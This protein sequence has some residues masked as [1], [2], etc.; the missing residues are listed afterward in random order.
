MG[1]LRRTDK[2]EAEIRAQLCIDIFS[3]NTK[4]IEYSSTGSILKEIA[5]EFLEAMEGA[6]ENPKE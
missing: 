4:K 2:D 3:R 1:R 6:R 5:Q